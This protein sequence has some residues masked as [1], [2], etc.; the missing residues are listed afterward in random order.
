MTLI[1]HSPQVIAEITA[2]LA[3]WVP[4]EE[5]QAARIDEALAFTESNY[6]QNPSVDE[7]N[8][9]LYQTE[10]VMTAIVLQSLS[11]WKGFLELGLSSE[12]HRL[13]QVKTIERTEQTLRR[14][15]K[16]Y[17]DAQALADRLDNPRLKTFENCLQQ[18]FT[19]ANRLRAAVEYARA[20]DANNEDL[21]VCLNSRCDY[22]HPFELVLR[23][24][25]DPLRQNH[26]LALLQR[27]LSCGVN[28]H[29]GV[30]NQKT[31]EALIQEQRPA[32]LVATLFGQDKSLRLGY[33]KALACLRPEP[34]KLNAEGMSRG[35]LLALSFSA[36]YYCFMEDKTS[37]WLATL[38]TTAPLLWLGHHGAFDDD[39]EKLSSGSLLG[40]HL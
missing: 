34:S 39:F 26:A 23:G 5:L 7:V 19:V 33:Q 40:F 1:Q 29:E 21:Y 35:L 11:D 24:L 25:Q 10:S 8:D 15:L 6:P 13:E 20:F 36:Y 18:L 38:L 14:L 3:P 2:R 32:W 22:K 17:R 16:L 37:F 31:L 28:P 4:Q 30:R 12:S 9:Y 27:L